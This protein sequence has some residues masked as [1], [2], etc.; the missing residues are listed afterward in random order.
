MKEYE[1]AGIATKLDNNYDISTNVEHDYDY[2][3]QRV[4]WSKETYSCYLD[5]Q[6]VQFK[7]V[8]QAEDLYGITGDKLCKGQ[9]DIEV[10]LVPLAKCCSQKTL[11]K[12]NAGE[13]SPTN[14]QDL[15]DYGCY[16]VMGRELLEGVKGDTPMETEVVQD[17]IKA[18][19]ASMTCF[20]GMCGFYLDRY[21]NR[22]GSTGWDYL[23]DWCQDI[24]F[25]TAAL[26]RW[27]AETKT[28]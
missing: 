3:E 16:V 20:G 5:E 15:Y 18:A 17:K 24:D 6:E 4:L 14:E 7:L 10:L 2:G 8:V 28:A 23:A 19:V 13:G 12:A 9:V 1:F 22:I 27:K 26:D 21:Q 25:C 11:E